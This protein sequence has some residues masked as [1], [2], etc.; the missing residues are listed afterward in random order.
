MQWFDVPWL[1]QNSSFVDIRNL[2]T[3]NLLYLMFEIVTLR[4]KL[5]LAFYVISA[6]RK[7]MC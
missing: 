1:M 7:A 4:G 6:T 5:A 3:R 2:W